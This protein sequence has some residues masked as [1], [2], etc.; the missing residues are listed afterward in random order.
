MIKFMGYFTLYSLIKFSCER[1]S[2]KDGKD[3]L[4][5]NKKEKM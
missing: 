2:S 3:I 5:E 4:D 1:G